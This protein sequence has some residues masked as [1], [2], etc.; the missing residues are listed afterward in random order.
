MLKMNKLVGLTSTY[1]DHAS[2]ENEVA[3]SHSIGCKMIQKEVNCEKWLASTIFH[4]IAKKDMWFPHPEKECYLRPKN[5]CEIALNT[6]DKLNLKY[7]TTDYGWGGT[8]IT[9]K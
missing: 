4:F 5:A 3:T 2:T 7:S 9:L 8:S 1:I 6:L